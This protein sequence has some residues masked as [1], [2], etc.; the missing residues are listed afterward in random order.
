MYIKHI[1]SQISIKYSTRARFFAIDEQVLL[2][3][4][5]YTLQILNRNIPSKLKPRQNI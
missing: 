5:C 3:Y 1:L 4:I 2:L